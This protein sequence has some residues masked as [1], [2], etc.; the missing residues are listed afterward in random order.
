MLDDILKSTTVE[1]KVRKQNGRV[2]FPKWAS[3]CLPLAFWINPRHKGPGKY[4]IQASSSAKSADSHTGFYHQCSRH[5]IVPLSA[6]P[7]MNFIRMVQNSSYRRISPG[8]V[9]Y[10][11]MA[12]S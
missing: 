3:V 7:Q 12:V 8:D 6:G 5:L 1:G 4:V 2:E 11:M 10:S 9:R